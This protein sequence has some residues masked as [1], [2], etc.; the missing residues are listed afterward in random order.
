MVLI[1]STTAFSCAIV[2]FNLLGKLFNVQHTR[3]EPFVLGIASISKMGLAGAFIQVMLIV[4]FAVASF[5]GLYT[6]PVLSKLRPLPGNTPFFKIMLNCMVL[7]ILSSALPLFTRTVGITNFD[8]FGNFGQIEWTQNYHLVLVYNCAF[9]VAL[10]ICLCHSIVVKLSREFFARL[11]SLF[12][13]LQNCISLAH[14]K[15]CLLRYACTQSS[16][17][18][19]AAHSVYSP[20]VPGVVDSTTPT[21]RL[22]ASRLFRNT[23]HSSVTFIYSVLHFRP[24]EATATSIKESKS[25]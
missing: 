22:Y 5:V 23:L 3:A 13:C 19:V 24:V 18:T 4:Y 2:F 6:L 25:K 15:L 20:G 12:L 1:I 17:A 8:L 10:V 16:S 9:L 14:E 11:H 7:L 21:A